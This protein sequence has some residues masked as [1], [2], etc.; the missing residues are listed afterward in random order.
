MCP[1]CGEPLVAYELDNIEVDHCVAC[2]GTW[3]DAGELEMIA[4]Q[5]GVTSGAMSMALQARRRGRATRRR[6]PRCPRR[7]REIDLG[8]TPSVSIDTCPWGHGLWF[9]RGEMQ[10]VIRSFAGGEEGEVARFF[11]ELYRSENET[12]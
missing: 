11:A 5:A 2:L 7:L 4:E 10:E 3:L 6:C 8:E 9:D 1:V 12:A